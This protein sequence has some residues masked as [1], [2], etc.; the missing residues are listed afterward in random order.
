[1]SNTQKNELKSAIS[2]LVRAS[3][4]LGAITGSY[5]WN[6]KYYKQQE[7]QKKVDALLNKLHVGSD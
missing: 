2:D 7:A 5:G 6:E 4:E 1:M 3:E